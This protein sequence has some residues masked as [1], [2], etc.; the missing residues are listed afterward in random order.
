MNLFRYKQLKE[1]L[2]NTTKKMDA[3]QLL[4]RPNI[5]PPFEL[6]T[7]QITYFLNVNTIVETHFGAKIS[8][9]TEK[10]LD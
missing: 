8:R 7:F 1:Y 10:L 5:Y 3:I 9:F 4:L 2:G 6:V